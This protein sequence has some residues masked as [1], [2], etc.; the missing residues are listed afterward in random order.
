MTVPTPRPGI[1][2][3]SPYVPGQERLGRWRR[4]AGDQAF[5]ERI[6]AGAQPQGCRC[7]QG[8][9]RD[10]RYGIPTAAPRQLREAIGAHHGLDSRADRLQRRIGRA[11]GDCSHK[12]YAG[13]GDEV[14][15]SQYGFALYPIATLA[16]GATPVTAPET[17]YHTDVDAM[18]AIMS[19]RR[20]S[21]CSWPTPT[22]RPAAISA[23]TRSTACATACLIMCC[24]CLDSA[25]AEFVDRD[26]Y[27]AGRELV[28]AG[29]NTVM[30]RTFSKIYALAGLRIGWLYGPPAIVDVLNRIRA[31]FNVSSVA[32]RRRNRRYRR[33]RARRQ[34][35]GAQPAV[36]AA[37][38]PVPAR[39]GAHR[40][41]QRGELPAGPVPRRPAI[42][43]KPPRTFWLRGASMSAI[44]SPTA[45]PTA[46]ASISA[47]MMKWPR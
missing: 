34:G 15:Y 44:S 40:P 25:Y 37:P 35:A 21:S 45:C 19:V 16:A 23:A 6:G 20:R 29:E 5:L 30:T 28:D 46:C 10:H 2:E 1:M 47:W 12:A 41:S 11:S 22:T 3:I 26:D 27:S 24:W 39:H 42:R 7:R 4:P 43:P 38:D 13:P 18:L 33:S 32:H 14:L 36:A 31:P 8:G 17:D 9:G